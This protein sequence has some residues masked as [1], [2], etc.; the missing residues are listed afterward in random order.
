MSLVTPN[1]VFWQRFE[2]ERNILH[3]MKRRKANWIGHILRR[4][5]FLKH[6]LNRR[7]EGTGRRRSNVTSC[8]IILRNRD[9][10]GNWRRKHSI[11][12]WRKRFMRCRG[13]VAR[14]TVRWR[15]TY[16]S[17]F[18]LSSPEASESYVVVVMVAVAVVII[19]IISSSSI[20]ISIVP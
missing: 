2:E 9:D 4:N 5:C 8:C 3:P 14:P 18:Y 6:V 7:I 19:I 12:L 10:M 13:T 15:P 11:T 1:P 20:I 16:C 17:D